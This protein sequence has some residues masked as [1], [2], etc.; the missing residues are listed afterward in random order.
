MYY[1]YLMFL[2]QATSLIVPCKV[3]RDSHGFWIPWCRTRIPGTGFKK[4]CFPRFRSPKSRITD[5]TSKYFLYSGLQ[6][7]MFPDFGNLDLTWVTH[8]ITLLLLHKMLNFCIKQ[9]GIACF[10][11]FCCLILLTQFRGNFKRGGHI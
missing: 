5:S 6:E 11:F 7:Q 9:S 4:V 10:V 3:I 2:I 8:R 1:L